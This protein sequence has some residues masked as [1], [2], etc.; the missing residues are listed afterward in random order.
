MVRGA[1]VLGRVLGWI[2][3]LV[4]AALVLWCVLGG[5]AGCFDF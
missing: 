4:I 5:G 3:V 2:M 1:L